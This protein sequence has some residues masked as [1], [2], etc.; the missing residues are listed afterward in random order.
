MTATKRKPTSYL[1]IG[2]GRVARHLQHYFYLL[3]EFK[4]NSEKQSSHSDSR[5]ISEPT[6][7]TYSSSAWI[8]DTWDRAQDPLALTRKIEAADHILLAIS[9]DA[10]ES[11]YYKHLDGLEKICVHFSGAK[12]IPNTVAAHPLMTFG[13]DLYDL[14]FYQKIHFVMTGASDLQEA[15]PDF[16][17]SSSVLF[18]AEK[19]KYHALCVIGGNFTNLLISKMLQEFEAYDIPLEASRLYIDKVIENVFADRGHSLTGPLA[20]KDLQTIRA[21][22]SAL[23]S[24]PYE[25]I[26]ESFVKAY[27]PDFIK[28]KE[29][30]S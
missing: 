18:S 12:Q 11:F 16:M 5:P 17:N 13:H 27:I 1:I 26:Y 4:L 29:G 8:L 14:D 22:L 6:S 2:S 10:L 30:E 7:S 24:D 28:K 25:E 21:N 20:R 9:D 19:A 15:I 23:K 3:K